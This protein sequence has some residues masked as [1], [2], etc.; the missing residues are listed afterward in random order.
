MLSCA[1]YFHIF[2]YLNLTTLQNG[3]HLTLI[4]ETRYSKMSSHLFKV[5]ARLSGRVRNQTWSVWSTS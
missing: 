2:S 3:Q 4:G 1:T 5:I